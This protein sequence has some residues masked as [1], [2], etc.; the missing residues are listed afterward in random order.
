MRKSPNE[1]TPAFVADAAQL[2]EALRTQSYFLDTL[3]CRKLVTYLSLG[4]PVGLRGE[5]GVGK[6]ELPARIAAWLEARLIDIECHS[7]LEA[8]DIGVSWNG[9]RQIVDAQTGHLQGEPFSLPYLND[10][11]LVASLRSQEPVVVRVDEVDKLSEHTSNF[12]LRY[13]D[14]KELVIHDLDTRA[15]IDKTLRAQAPIYIFLTSNDY[16]ALDPAMMRRI[17]W[18]EL[19][20]PAE[21]DLVRIVS[22]KTSVSEAIARRIGYIVLRLRDLALTKK[23]SIGEVLDFANGLWLENA[24]V[25][26]LDALQVT[27]G[28]LLKYPE[29]ARM[30][31]EALRTWYGSGSV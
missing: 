22:T 20:F 12:F 13:L 29:D 24:G 10:T 25:I 26:T 5:P 2:Q 28:L 31:W 6:S 18:L 11:P 23:P 19:S 16:Q 1:L 14:K 8:M 21:D 3:S 9:L 15:G 30:G 17:A 4:K 27:I 7:Q